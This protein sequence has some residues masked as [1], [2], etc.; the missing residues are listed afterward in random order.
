MNL[1]KCAFDVTAGRF[2]GFIVHEKGIQTDPKKVE[3]IKNLEEP[4]CKR[5]VQ[6]LLGK[7][8]YLRRFISNLAGKV[9]SFFPLVRLKHDGEF[10]WGKNTCELLKRSKSIYPVLRA[11][12]VGEAFGLYIIAQVSVVGA[13]LT[14]EEGGKEFVVAYMDRRLLDAETRYVYIEKLCL[15]LYHA[16]TKFRQYLLS[17]TCVVVCHHDMIEYMLHKP[18]LSGRVG[19]WVYSLVEYD[20]V[21]EPLRAMRGQIVADFIVDHS[22]EVSDDVHMVEVVPWNLFFDGSVCSKGQGIGCIITSPNKAV[23]EISIRLGFTYTNN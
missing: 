22:V 9:E 2:L 11:P 6:K 10:A 13:V 16:C 5:D 15:S 14:R 8:N 3:S 12:K 1:L 4:T 18:I 20:L 21:H 17:S 7:I 23:F 19:K